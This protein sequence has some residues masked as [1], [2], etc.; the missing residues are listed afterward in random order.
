MDAAT[1]A[2]KL[3][4]KVARVARRQVPARWHSSTPNPVLAEA[5]GRR[6]SASSDIREHLATIFCETVTSQPRLIV[7]LGTRD[8]VSTRALLA[9]AEICDAQLLSID[10]ADCS[11]IDLPERLRARWTFVCADDVAFAGEPFAAFC[12]GR[13]LEPRAEV[14]FI[15][16]SHAYTHTRA[17]LAAWVPRLSDRG[18]MMFHDTNMG[19]GW[20]RLLNGKAER[21]SDAGRGVISAIEEVLGRRY[22]ETTYFADIVG[23]YVVRHVPWSSGFTVLRRLGAEASI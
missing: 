3:Y 16:T 9:A 21:G 22:D 2:R 17:E 7:E 23:G 15:D 4:V 14:I 20:F 5:L 11:A 19:T 13:G 8:G 12:A 1:S 6:A 18:T 10:I